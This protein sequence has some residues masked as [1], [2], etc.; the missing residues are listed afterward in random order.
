M[1]L[2]AG[3]VHLMPSPRRF[4]LWAL[5]ECACT[6]RT[7]G[8]SLTDIVKRVARLTVREKMARPISVIR[9]QEPIRKSVSA[10]APKSICESY[11]I[12]ITHKIIPDTGSLRCKQEASGGRAADAQRTAAQNN[13]P[14]PVNI[15]YA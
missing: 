15:C 4:C 1:K 10:V 3:A 5:G 6:E 14:A 8:V 13:V 7:P 11:P 12:N 2:E 9:R